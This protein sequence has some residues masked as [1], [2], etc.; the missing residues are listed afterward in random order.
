MD[1][2]SIEVIRKKYALVPRTLIFIRREDKFLL[3]HKRKRDS[4][5][6][7]KFNGVG[8]HIEKGEEPFGSARRE[9]LEETGLSITNLDLAAILFID[10]GDTPGIEV[11]LFG[12]V[13]GG[14]EILQSD[15]GELSWVTREEIE[16]SDQILEDVPMLIDLSVEN[17][18][19]D[20]PLIITY[21]YDEDGT[22]RVDIVNH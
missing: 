12:A 1:D 2:Y 5:G 13:Y 4:Y 16:L 3:I 7:G 15:E 22:L 8:G 10:I 9:I 18:A 21:S 19:G 17:S 20:V 14:G 11:F 6:F